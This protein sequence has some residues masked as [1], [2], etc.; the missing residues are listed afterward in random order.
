MVMS[1]HWTAMQCPMKDFQIAHDL[2]QQGKKQALKMHSFCSVLRPPLSNSMCLN[3]SSMPVKYLQIQQTLF[4]R[5]MSRET[6]FVQTLLK[7]TLNPLCL[8]KK[9]IEKVYIVKLNTGQQLHS[10]A[11]CKGGCMRQNMY[12]QNI[13]TGTAHQSNIPI[14]LDLCDDDKN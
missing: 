14:T 1:R 12:G 11:V 10:V 7:S 13:R 2:I 5:D 3:L 4:H 9:K 8:T 6:C